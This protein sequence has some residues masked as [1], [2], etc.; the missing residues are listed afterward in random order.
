MAA[1]R[2]QTHGRASL[3]YNRTAFL[4]ESHGRAILQSI[5][6]ITIFQSIP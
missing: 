5:G 1:I 3:Q 6:P 2:V 4:V